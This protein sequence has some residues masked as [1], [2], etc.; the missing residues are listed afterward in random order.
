EL[1]LWSAQLS[2]LNI[3]EPLW[4]VLEKRVRSRFSSSTSLKQLTNILIKEW[5]NILLEI[6]QKFHNSI[7]R[8]IE[9]LLKA[10]GG[11][12]FY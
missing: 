1:L 11:L 9:A 8:R 7:P 3:I 10:N 6:I 4:T 5:D 12:T 2:N